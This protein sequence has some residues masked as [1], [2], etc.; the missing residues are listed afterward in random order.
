MCAC[1]CVLL[2]ASMHE[3]TLLHKLVV[4]N[5]GI[6]IVLIM[7]HRLACF[8]NIMLPSLSF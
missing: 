6:N 8:V 4:G 5:K 1:I 2:K 7:M 3:A